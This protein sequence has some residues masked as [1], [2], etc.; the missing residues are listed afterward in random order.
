MTLDNG[1]IIALVALE[2]A[3]LGIVSAVV[4]HYINNYIIRRIEQL[5]KQYAMLG[6]EEYVLSNVAEKSAKLFMLHDNAI[7]NHHLLIIRMLA[8]TG[9]DGNAINIYRQQFAY[10]RRRTNRTAQTLLMY[11]SRKD[12]QLSALRQLSEDLGGIAELRAMIELKQHKKDMND[13]VDRAIKDLT[14]RLD[15]IIKGSEKEGCQA[16]NAESP[17]KNNTEVE[18][19]DTSATT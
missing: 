5:E 10:L 14:S 11:S 2:I 12:W 15:E 6:S 16:K 9:V 13:G 18:S 4:F 8:S 17:Q 1:N 19:E 3:V 7:M